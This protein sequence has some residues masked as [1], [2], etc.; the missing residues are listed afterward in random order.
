MTRS[1]D[2]IEKL[3]RDAGVPRSPVARLIMTTAENLNAAETQ[4]TAKISFLRDTLSRRGQARRD[5]PA[6]Q[7]PRRAAADSRRGRPAPH[8][9]R[10]AER[11]ARNAHHG[12]VRG[13]STL[14]P[15]PARRHAP[16]LRPQK[17][18][19]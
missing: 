2:E 3:T 12:R 16:P 7:P 8:P 10:A 19:P 9:L 15:R 11:P 14:S 4:I 13:S 17:G 6:L 18:K 1:Y 5:Q